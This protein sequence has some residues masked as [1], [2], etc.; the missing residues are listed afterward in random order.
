MVRQPGT[1]IRLRDAKPCI[2]MVS[3]IAAT[4]FLRRF[5]MSKIFL[6]AG[7]AAS[8]VPALALSA[9]F[10][11][12]APSSLPLLSG[13]YVA[14]IHQFCQPK[15][16]VTYSNQGVVENVVL[17]AVDDELESGTM[18][19]VQGANPGTGTVKLSITS[20]GGSPFLVKNSGESGSSG[21]KLQMNTGSV[22]STFKQTASTI[23]ITESSGTSTYNV[24]Y[25]KVSGGIVQHAVFAGIDDKGCASQGSIS[26][27]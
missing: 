20:V 8:L 7:V 1:P 15:E 9:P 24:Y 26:I 6:A 2:K 12:Q 11:T 18:A 13:T 22:S 16:T 10:A 19:F 4:I 3:T 21:V 17:S 23:A 5:W 14:T 25:G 27:K